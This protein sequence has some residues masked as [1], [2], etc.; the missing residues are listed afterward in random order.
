MN[1]KGTA[2]LETKHLILRRFCI[3]DAKF[4][5]ENWASDD[6]VTK[7]LT[8]PTHS[9]ISISESVLNSW[10]PLYKK[11][12]YY[13]WAVVL[14][15]LG[16]PIGSTGA[17][18]QRDDIKMVHIGYCIGRTWW[19]KGYTSEIL[20]ELNRFF[21]EEIGVKSVQSR[22]DPR[23]PA[24]GKVMEKCGLKY[25][26]TLR[27]SDINNQGIC[28]AAHYSILAEEYFHRRAK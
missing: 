7:Y 6:E 19:G 5:F 25:E 12:D 15:E 24:S 20:A 17:V 1:H 14:K 16:V 10:T 27:Q 28:D 11:S 8:W 21:F 3:E 26:G 2:T 13:H 22:H 4:M 23:N 18:E 9:D